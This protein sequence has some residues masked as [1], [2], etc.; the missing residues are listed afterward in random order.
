MRGNAIFQPQVAAQPIQP[1]L[2]PQLNLNK[3]VG[4]D[5]YPIDGNDQ[6]LDQVVFDLAGLPGV[7]NRDEYIRQPQFA[8][9]LHGIPKKTE[10]YTNQAIA[11][12]AFSG[13]AN[14]VPTAGNGNVTASTAAAG[15]CASKSLCRAINTSAPRAGKLAVKRRRSGQLSGRPTC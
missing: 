13:S 14:V 2:C 10:N 1:F 12:R 15:V 4:P 7:G 5:Q 3:R 8:S 11:L 9:C 6:Q